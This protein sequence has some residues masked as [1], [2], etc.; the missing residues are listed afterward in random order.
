MERRDNQFRLEITITKNEIIKTELFDIETGEEYVLHEVKNAQGTYVASVRSEYDAVMDRIREACFE[1]EVFKSNQSKEVIQYMYDKYESNQEFLWEKFPDYAAFRNKNNNK[2]FALMMHVPKTK[3][4]I[5]EEGYVEI[6]DL[7]FNQ[8][9][10]EDFIDYKR[11]YPGYHMNKKHWY[12]IC[13]DNSV[14]IE[15]IKSFI[16]DSYQLSKK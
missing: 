10:I 16:D 6:L 3:L 4:T 12:T 11:Y 2:W 8:E 7:R 1:K 15:K 5:E 14:S 13:L 9:G